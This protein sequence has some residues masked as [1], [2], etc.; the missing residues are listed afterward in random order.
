MLWKQLKE[1]RLLNWSRLVRWC[2]SETCDCECRQC[3][4]YG[5]FVYKWPQLFIVTYMCVS[6]L[7]K[8]VLLSLQATHFFVG[9]GGSVT[10]FSELGVNTTHF[11]NELKQTLQTCIGLVNRGLLGT[12]Q[13][14]EG[15]KINEQSK[16]KAPKTDMT[17]KTAEEISTT[18]WNNNA[19]VNWPILR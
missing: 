5:I 11:Q 10:H 17:E 8:T 12:A 3:L 4:L 2:V 6:W 16:Y 14:D 15:I 1:R 9:T 13:T 7:L 18:V 19:T